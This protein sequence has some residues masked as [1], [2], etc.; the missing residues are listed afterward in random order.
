MISNRYPALKIEGSLDRAPHGIYDRMNGVGAHEVI[1]ETPE[2]AFDIV[3]MN[4]IAFT[5]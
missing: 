4:L 1:I 2:H 3:D 5:K